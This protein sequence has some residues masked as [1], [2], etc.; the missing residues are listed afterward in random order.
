MERRLTII[1]TVSAAATICAG[2]V[3]IGAVFGSPFAQAR[4]AVHSAVERVETVEDYIV[5]PSPTTTIAT[6]APASTPVIDHATFA[7]QVAAPAPVDTTPVTTARA[8]DRAA[9]A[10][11]PA[12]ATTLST[13][14]P[15]SPATTPAAP[16]TSDD[17]YGSHERH[18]SDDAGGDDTHN[19]GHEGGDD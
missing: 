16:P 4:P 1:Y 2:C 19:G 13:Q 10:P 6:T 18:Q 17:H 7:A 8:A 15:P 3:A 11:I 5:V 12:P 14:P 9:E